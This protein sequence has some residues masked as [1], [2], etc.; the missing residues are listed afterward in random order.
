[1]VADTATNEDNV[2]GATLSLSWNAVATGG[3]LTLSS[4]S[5]DTTG[6]TVRDLRAV[7]TRSATYVSD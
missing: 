7:G 5:S 1:M 3:G 6:W 4:T 2:G